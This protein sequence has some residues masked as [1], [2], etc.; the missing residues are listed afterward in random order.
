MCLYLENG[1]LNID[2]VLSLNSTFN[3]ITGGRGTGKT[4]GLLDTAIRQGKNTYI[5]AVRRPILI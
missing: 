1:Y 5:S 2:Y 3:L 4:F